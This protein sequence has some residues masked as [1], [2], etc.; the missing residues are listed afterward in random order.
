M[1]TIKVCRKL[2]EDRLWD[3]SPTGYVQLHIDA[4]NDTCSLL[5]KSETDQSVLL[6][7]EIRTDTIYSKQKETVIVWSEDNSDIALYFQERSGCEEVRTL[8]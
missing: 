6:E 8:P 3:V 2:D 1:N 4:S 5:V 7:S